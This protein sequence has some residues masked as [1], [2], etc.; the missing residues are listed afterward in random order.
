MEVVKSELGV[1]FVSEPVGL[2]NLWDL[3]FQCE[4]AVHG[5]LSVQNNW[6]ALVINIAFT[7]RQDE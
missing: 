7:R 3:C 1:L 2:P 6:F 4:S 5:I